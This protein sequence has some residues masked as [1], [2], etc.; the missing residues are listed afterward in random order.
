MAGTAG[1]GGAWPARAPPMR[2]RAAIKRPGGGALCP[3]SLMPPASW[4]TSGGAFLCHAPAS[5][6]AG[7]SRTKGGRWWR[8]NQ[9]GPAALFFRVRVC[10]SF[11]FVDSR[12][13]WLCFFRFVVRIRLSRTGSTLLC[14]RLIPMLSVRITQSVDQR[15]ISLFSLHEYKRGS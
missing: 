10:F 9:V 8:K 6:V 4:T 7:A 14:R 13:I 11:D 15:G 2:E 3:R 1:R 12:S 5:G